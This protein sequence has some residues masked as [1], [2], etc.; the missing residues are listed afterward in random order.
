M[1]RKLAIV[2]LMLVA[3]AIL[4]TQPV[5]A[6]HDVAGTAEFHNNI[7]VLGTT[8]LTRQEGA[9]VFNDASV[10][11]NFNADDSSARR[12]PSFLLGAYC[13]HTRTADNSYI[14]LKSVIGWTR[15]AL[16]TTEPTAHVSQIPV[17]NSNSPR[18]TKPML[19]AG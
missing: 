1:W 18:Q 5:E 11:L 2:A 10:A 17:R 8:A 7:D 9:L 19:R 13:F 15:A 16:T 6:R 3:L 12:F 14:L 4:G